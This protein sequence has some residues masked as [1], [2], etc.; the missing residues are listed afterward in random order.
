MVRRHRARR[1]AAE[2]PARA[3]TPSPT[4]SPRRASCSRKPACCSRGTRSGRVRVARRRRTITRGSS[5]IDTD[6]HSGETA[7]A[8]GGRARAS[9]PRARRADAVRALGDAAGRHA[10]VRHAL[11]HDARAAAPDAGARRHRDDAQH[12]AD[13]RR[14]DRAVAERRDRAAAADLDD[15]PRDRAVCVGG[16]GA[17]AGPAAPR[18]PPA[19]AAARAGRAPHAGRARR[20][21][22]SGTGR[23]TSRC[24][25]PASCSSTAA[26][27]AGRAA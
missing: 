27:A 17:R 1:T 25:K 16:R 22:A 15:A 21:A 23:P 10:P 14:R 9:A 24:R 26:G 19:A 8:R 7:V 18:C 4:T 3:R 5:S 2:R 6:V 20:S 11:L 13:G 12:L